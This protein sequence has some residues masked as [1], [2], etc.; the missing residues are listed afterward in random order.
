MIHHRFR[1]SDVFLFAALLLILVGQEAGALPPPPL[2]GSEI[3]DELIE[4]MLPRDTIEQQTPQ[5]SPS[6]PTWLD[7]AKKSWDAP[8]LAKQLAEDTVTIPLGKGAIFVPRFTESSLEPEFEILD[9]LGEIIARGNTGVSIPVLPGRYYLLIGSGSQD[10]A[11]V[12]DVHVAESKRTPVIPDWCGLVSDVANEDNFLFRG[13]YELVRIDEF[14]PY[15]RGYGPDPGLGERVKTWI[16]PPGIYK[17]FSVGESYNSLKNF[18]T[19]QLLPG[20]L[21]KFLL[22][23]NEEDLKI[24][25]GGIVDLK[26][27]VNIARNWRY[28][29]DVGGSLDFN[30]IYD[31]LDSANTTNE[32]SLSL[33]SSFRL[34]FQKGPVEWNSRL[35]VDQGVSFT[36]FDLSQAS[37]A[38]DEVRLNSIFT[39]RF[40]KWLG[41]YGRLE[42]STEL[43]PSYARAPEQVNRHYFI[44]ANARDSLDITSSIDSTTSS[45]LLEP[46]FSPSRFE[47][48]IGANMDIVT[49]RFFNARLLA[50]F[51]F[52]QESHTNK[53][54]ISDT[55]YF[56]ASFDPS[57][58]SSPYAPYLQALNNNE[59]AKTY[60]RRYGSTTTRPEY[61][62]EAV[63][64][65]TTYLGRLATIES[66]FKVFLPVE[67]FSQSDLK[68]DIRFWTTVSWRIVKSVTLDY[69]YEYA[70]RWPAEISARSNESRHRVLLRFSYTSR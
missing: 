1:F 33:L 59:I 23:E 25:G 40:L 39:W 53:S 43:F 63:A 31:R 9:S 36:K 37:S 58:P 56:P 24:I 29:V 32:M 10:Q 55:A 15:G 66:E 4:Q 30:A 42:G 52:T 50:G 65:I 68:P 44:I 70:L 47:V 34:L 3:E 61:G 17:I 27:N 26:T 19:V 69:R 35:K 13:E 18:V 11:V 2:P 16:L 57:D 28:G 46:S 60:I 38:T 14:E 45:Y 22:I 5:H 64:N 20:K 62:P 67:R 6:S 8:S 12:K 7:H 49:T 21:T 41:P 51:G 48:G 54:E